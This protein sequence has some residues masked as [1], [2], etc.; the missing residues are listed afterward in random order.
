MTDHSYYM[1]LAL[2]QAKAMK[3]QTDPNPLVGCVIVNGSRI[4][5][6]GSHLKAGEAHAEVH[7]LRM[8]GEHAKGATM[9]VTLEPCSHHGRTGPCA[10]AVVRAGV[11]KVV[12]ATLDPNPVVSGNGV[13][14]LKKAGIEVITGICEQESVKINEVFNKYIVT[15]R[16]FVSLKVGS[17]L[18]GKIATHTNSSK[19][20]TSEEART[21]VHRLRHENMAIL[22]GI[23]TVLEDNPALTARIP[24]GKNPIRIVLD[25]TLKI[26]LDCQ[27]VKDNKAETW[28]FTTSRYNEE[29]KELLEA[30]GVHVIVLERDY[31][32][33]VEVL[34]YMGKKNISSLLVEAGAT[35]NASFIEHQLVDKLVV[36]MAPKLVGGQQAP[37]FLGG[38]GAEEMQDAI[39]LNNLQVE[40]IGSDL[41]ITGY[42]VIHGEKN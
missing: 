38:T 32:H 5:G 2:N 21:D 29:K 10:E 39:E 24:N 20:I 9:Y 17:S 18:D 31:I 30:N 11:A 23:N 13:A 33:P 35:I 15:Q 14:I 19:W 40:T 3:G 27:L 12:V 37:S 8:A 4:V 6:I 16:P 41:K 25:S 28:V 26:P 1:E 42:P 34:D 22:T 36:Y 7:A